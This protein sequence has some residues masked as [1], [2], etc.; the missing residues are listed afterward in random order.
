MYT[1]KPAEE[2]AAEPEPVV[3]PEDPCADGHE[4]TEWTTSQNASWTKDGVETRTCKDCGTVETRV[5]EENWINWAVK[6]VGRRL[7]RFFS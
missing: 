2:P 1:E 6:A 3:E 7:K 4:Y 5:V